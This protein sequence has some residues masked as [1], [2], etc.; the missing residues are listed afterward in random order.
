MMALAPPREPSAGS[1]WPARSARASSP[2]PVGTA[3]AAALRGR[4]AAANARLAYQQYERVFSSS[5]WK[6]LQAA[7]A[8]PQQ[9]LRA[10]T[11]VK[12]PAYPATRYLAAPG[13]VNTMPEATPCAWSPTTARCLPARYTATTTSPSKCST[14]CASSAS[15]TTT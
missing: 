3:E 6:A 7:G 15:T 11:S 1:R 5:R 2:G 8:R 10:S 9:P 13:V 12:D 4:A 14:D